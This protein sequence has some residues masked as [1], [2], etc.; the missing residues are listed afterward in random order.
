MKKMNNSKTNHLKAKK[1]E[2]KIENEKK[3]QQ[4][5]KQKR[6]ILLIIAL[7]SSVQ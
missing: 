4:I 2:I 6:G 1:V 5:I 3:S 7:E